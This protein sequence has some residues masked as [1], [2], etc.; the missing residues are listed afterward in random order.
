MSLQDCIQIA[1]QH[2][3]TIQI[4]RYNPHGIVSPKNR[5]YNL[6]AAYRRVADMSGFNYYARPDGPLL[7]DDLALLLSTSGSTGSAK[8]VRLARKNLDSNSAGVISA[9]AIKSSTRVG[10]PK[11]FIA[12]TVST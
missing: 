12:P 5:D 1:L 4:A 9:L 2:N 8:L 6:S 10:V 11:G 3:F 7:H